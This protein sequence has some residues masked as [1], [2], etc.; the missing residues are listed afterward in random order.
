LQS[1]HVTVEKMQKWMK[2]TEVVLRYP[3]HMESLPNAGFSSWTSKPQKE[4]KT[5][6]DSDPNEVIEY[7]MKTLR[8]MH[9]LLEYFLQK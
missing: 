4:R 8:K 7:Y 3:G 5:E 1:E 9:E 6:K 2:V